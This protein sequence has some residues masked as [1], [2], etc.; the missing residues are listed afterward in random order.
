MVN[1]EFGDHLTP[2]QQAEAD[3]D[4]SI[5]RILES[6]ANLEDPPVFQL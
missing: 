4:I 1:P 3:H 2:S 5:E 6:H